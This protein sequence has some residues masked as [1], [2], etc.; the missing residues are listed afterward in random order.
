ML[1]KHGWG[2]ECTC[3][4][5]SA[6]EETIKESD[7][8]VEQILALQKD[9]DDYTPGSAATPE[10][11]ERLVK[12][13]KEEGLVTRMVEAYYRAAVEYNGIGSAEEAIRFAKLC[14]EEGEVLES[15]IGPF[16]NNMRELIREASAHWTWKFRLSHR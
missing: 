2:F 12:L 7:E 4:H 5:C 6:S 15:S 11:A 16:M 9:L 10:K 1:S 13:F 3:S 14:I 8:R